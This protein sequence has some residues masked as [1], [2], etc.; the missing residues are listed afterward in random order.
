MQKTQGYA[1][2]HPSEEAVEVRVAAGDFGR[3]ADLSIFLRASAVLLP[4]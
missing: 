3:A 2:K 4:F 1:E